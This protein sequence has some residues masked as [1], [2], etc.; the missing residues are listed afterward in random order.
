MDIQKLEV[1]RRRFG[2]FPVDYP[3][4]YILKTNSETLTGK[5]VNLSEGGLL[6][7]FLDRIGIGTE[8]DLEMFYVLELQFTALSTRARVVW[9]DIVETSEAIE[10]QCGIEFTEMDREEKARLCKLLGTMKPIDRYPREKRYH[11]P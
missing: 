8:L 9:K 7:Y 6:A 1:D 10:Y 3:I 4:S 5:A 2:R 11:S